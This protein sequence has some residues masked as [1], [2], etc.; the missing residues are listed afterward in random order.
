M[1]DRLELFTFGFFNEKFVLI[2]YNLE[3]VVKLNLSDFDEESYV[4]KLC[5]KNE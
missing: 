2:G 5:T 4:S 3:E 1:Y